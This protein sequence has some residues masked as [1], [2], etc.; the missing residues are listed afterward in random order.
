MHAIDH[1]EIKQ[2]RKNLFEL[3]IVGTKSNDVDIEL[4]SHVA[5][6]I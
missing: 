4:F 2:N 1:L 5:K 3:M 6:Y